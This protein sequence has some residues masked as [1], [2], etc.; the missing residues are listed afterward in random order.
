M[1]WIPLDA[2]AT[3]YL[4]KNRQYTEL[5]ALF[6]VQLDYCQGSPATVAG[7]AIQWRWSRDRVRTW[8]TALGLHIE[9]QKGRNPGRLGI[10]SA[11]P[12][13]PHSNQP[14][15]VSQFRAVR[16]FATPATSQRAASKSTATRHS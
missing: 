12:Q 3:R 14:P 5:E 11:S 4:P 13:Q 10:K 1:S 8:L 9:G 7:Y 16:R 15:N 2:R 6:A